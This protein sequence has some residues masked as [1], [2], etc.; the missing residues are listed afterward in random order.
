MARRTTAAS[1]GQQQPAG[2]KS[3]TGGAQ[4]K[5]SLGRLSKG[6]SSSLLPALPASIRSPPLPRYRPLKLISLPA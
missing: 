5:A 4:A 3:A 2:K 1:G 6:P